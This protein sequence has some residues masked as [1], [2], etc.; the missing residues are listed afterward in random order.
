M[1]NNTAQGRIDQRHRARQHAS[2]RGAVDEAIVRSE[3]LS[4]RFLANVQ[5]TGQVLVGVQCGTIRKPHCINR[6]ATA[7]KLILI[8]KSRPGRT[9]ALT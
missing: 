4:A 2:V 1:I 3:S 8:G 6:P 9:A 7:P 5:G